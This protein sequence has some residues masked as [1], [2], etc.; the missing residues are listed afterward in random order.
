MT[1][2]KIG[3]ALLEDSTS[4]AAAVRNAAAT[5]VAVVHGG[6]K[7]I[8]RELGRMN[9]E[10]HFVDGLRVTDPPTLEAVTRA[11][12]GEVMPGLVHALARSG[13]SASGAFGAVKAT[14][15]DG[16]W[17]L[18]GTAL[19]VDAGML[20]ALLDSNKVPVVPTL[21]LGEETLL[22]V[23][24]DETA[25]AVAVALK[26]DRLLF[27]TDVEGVRGPDGTVLGRV[28]DVSALLDADFITGGMRPK[29]TAVRTALEAG[30]RHVLVGRTAFGATA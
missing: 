8:S 24:G 1:V 14:R 15:R 30:V 17:G 22:N 18:V 28:E 11:L 25:A 16:P 12:L 7:Q 26:A 5:P 21:A 3:G 23:N 20:R 9:I 4:A 27:L 19:H 10:S 13:L 29:L 2:V 6:G